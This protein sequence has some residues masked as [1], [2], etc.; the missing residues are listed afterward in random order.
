MTPPTPTSARKPSRAATQARKEALE[1]GMR[2]TLDDHEYVVRL[3]DVTA[4]V[5]RELRAATGHGF[6]W[7][8]TR[9]GEDP[10]VDLIAEFVW[11]ARRLGGEEVALEDVV[12]SYTD[13][14]SDGFDVTEVDGAED[15]QGPE[16]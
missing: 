12:V 2:I 9:V 3:G 11:L 4:Q 15:D 16:A 6:H 10:D 8:V 13:L 5:A 14:L 1:T 7:L